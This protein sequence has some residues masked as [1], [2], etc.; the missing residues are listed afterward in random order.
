MCKTCPKSGCNL[1]DALE[2]ARHLG[3]AIT[4]VKKTGELRVGHLLMC[5]PVKVNERRKDC[6]RELSTFLRR[7]ERKLWTRAA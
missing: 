6:P 5:K 7:L 3:C 1:R 4:D 2:Y